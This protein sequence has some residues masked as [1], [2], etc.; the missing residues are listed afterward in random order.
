M[1]PKMVIKLFT[2]TIVYDDEIHADI[3]YFTLLFHLPRCLPIFL[4]SIHSY[5][6]LGLAR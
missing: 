6:N 4:T 3:V 1:L 2:G 5:L